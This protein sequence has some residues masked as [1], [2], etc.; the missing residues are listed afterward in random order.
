VDGP[1]QILTDPYLLF[2]GQALKSNGK[3]LPERI[4]L[5]SSEKQIDVIAAVVADGVHGLH[6]SR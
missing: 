6:L 4:L 2:Q 3:E 5:S 1:A